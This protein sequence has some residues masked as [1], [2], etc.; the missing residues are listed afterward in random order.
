[1]QRSQERGAADGHEPECNRRMER[2]AADGHEPEC[3][4][5]IE[6][7]EAAALNPSPR[8]ARGEA[9]E[10]QDR[11]E[12]LGFHA[13]LHLVNEVRSLIPTFSPRKKGLKH[14]LFRK[15]AELT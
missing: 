15:Y 1:M 6:H 14:L 4:D 11:V 13:Q 12:R 10:G 7:N 8:G 2:G 3:S 5:R 9:G